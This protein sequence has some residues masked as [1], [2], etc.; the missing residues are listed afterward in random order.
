MTYIK[1]FI[2]HSME[3][4]Y[5]ELKSKKIKPE[6]MHDFISEEVE[7][8]LICATLDF[9]GFHLKN[10]AEV[11]GMSPSTLNKKIK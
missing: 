11:L 4:H 8:G 9:T 7:K 6:F 3:W 1:D 5:Q 2:Y 10:T